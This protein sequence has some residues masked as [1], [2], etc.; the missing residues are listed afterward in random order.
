VAEPS[1]SAGRPASQRPFC[2]IRSGTSGV[3]DVN[4]GMGGSRGAAPAPA[5]ALRHA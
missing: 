1:M 2:A 3:G 5:P 4:Q